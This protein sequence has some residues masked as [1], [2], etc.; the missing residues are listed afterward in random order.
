M[1]WQ[2]KKARDDDCCAR[3][4]GMLFG[5]GGH[6]VKDGVLYGVVAFGARRSENY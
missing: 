6:G 4:A 2:V 5:E 3:V 1:D